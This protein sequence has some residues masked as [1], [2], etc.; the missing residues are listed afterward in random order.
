MA[1]ADEQ[2]LKNSS[3]AG[4]YLLKYRTLWLRVLDVMRDG[5]DTFA[6]SFSLLIIIMTINISYGMYGVLLFPELGV[7]IYL[8]MYAILFLWALNDTCVGGHNAANQVRLY[9][10]EIKTIINN[11]LYLCSPF[12]LFV[13]SSLV[14]YNLSY[15]LFLKFIFLLHSNPRRKA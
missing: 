15:Y 11:T 3:L 8:G 2:L 13:F 12:P 4:H 9:V 7:G 14:L 5:G 6:W 1:T 10:E